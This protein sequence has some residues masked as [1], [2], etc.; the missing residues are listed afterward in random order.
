MS[1]VAAGQCD[2]DYIARGAYRLQQGMTSLLI[3]TLA[4]AIV[5]AAVAFGV[6]ASGVILRTEVR[7]RQYVPAPA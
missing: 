7:C 4:I 1:G 5:G 6:M 2:P 3:N